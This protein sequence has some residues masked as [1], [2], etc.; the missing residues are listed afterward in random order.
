VARLLAALGEIR[1]VIVGGVSRVGLDLVA[2]RLSLEDAA[3]ADGG[4]AAPV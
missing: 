3:H 4:S 2:E 1:P